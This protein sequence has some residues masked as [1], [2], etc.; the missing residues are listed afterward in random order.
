VCRYRDFRSVEILIIL[1]GSIVSWQRR[2][3]YRTSS[4]PF[5]FVTY[6]YLNLNLNSCRKRVWCRTMD[7]G[8][9]W[10]LASDPEGRGKGQAPSPQKWLSGDKLWELLSLW[11]SGS[12]LAMIK[13]F[14]YLPSRKIMFSAVFCRNSSAF[15]WATVSL[16]YQSGQAYWRSEPGR[17]TVQK[18]TLRMAGDCAKIRIPRPNI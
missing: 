15:D 13:F 17:I 9:E 14:A 5:V 7:Y 2:S 6:L 11:L 4:K 16:E 3:H 12:T 18:Q 10:N 8:L 1:Y